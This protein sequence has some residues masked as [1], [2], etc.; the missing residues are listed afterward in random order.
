MQEMP[1]NQRGALW[2][3][4]ASL[5]QDVLLELPPDRWEQGAEEGMEVES[6]TDPVS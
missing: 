3:K 5:L 1:R 4:L 6:N 2:E